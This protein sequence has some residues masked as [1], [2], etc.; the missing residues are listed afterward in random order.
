MPAGPGGYS[1]T[2]DAISKTLVAEG[3]LTTST[4]DFKP[5]AG[6]TTG[7]AHFQ[8]IKGKQNS[9]LSI[10]IALTG[11]MAQIANK[12]TSEQQDSDHNARVIP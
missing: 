2:T 12:N 9:A 11:G 7:L 5:G 10:G 1:A 8:T 4:T 3:F 6:G